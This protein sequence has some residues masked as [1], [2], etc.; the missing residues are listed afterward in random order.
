MTAAE[1][2]AYLATEGVDVVEMSRG[3]VILE[4]SVLGYINCVRAL[5]TPQYRISYVNGFGE[6]LLHFAAKGNQDQMAKY[7]LKRGADPNVKN[8]FR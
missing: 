2:E 4:C 5:E 8:R 7:L 1:A 3:E 6:G